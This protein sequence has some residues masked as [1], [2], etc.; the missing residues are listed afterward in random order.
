MTNNRLG[1]VCYVCVVCVC[2]CDVCV[3]DVCVCVCAVHIKPG[4]QYDAGAASV[5]SI[6]SVMG[7]SIFFTCQIASL[8]LNFHKI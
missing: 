1:C 5:T 4:S 2:A 6:V 8:S 3:C 7:K